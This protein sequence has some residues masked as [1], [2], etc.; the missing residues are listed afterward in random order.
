MKQK[1]YEIKI[2][3]YTGTI[4]KTW[5]ISSLAMAEREYQKDTKRSVQANCL[6]GIAYNTSK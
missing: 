2:D 3:P 1:S 5:D 4:E 6:N